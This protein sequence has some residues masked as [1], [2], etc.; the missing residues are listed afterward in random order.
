M[1]KKKKTKKKKKKYVMAIPGWGHEGHGKELLKGNQRQ[2]S[3]AECIF[4]IKWLFYNKA[5]PVPMFF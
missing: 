3:S 5:V 2:T 1:V 4:T